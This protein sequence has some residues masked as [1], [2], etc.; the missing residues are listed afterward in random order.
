V[1]TRNREALFLLGDGGLHLNKPFKE[2]GYYLDN[3][4]MLSSTP[5][6]EAM[7]TDDP[8]MVEALFQ[9]GLD[10]DI[11]LEEPDWNRHPYRAVLRAS[12]EPAPEMI[13]ALL[14]VV[15]DEDV[16]DEVTMG[17][18]MAIVDR[19]LP[20]KGLLRHM[21]NGMSNERVRVH[22]ASN[23]LLKTASCAN[24]P[25]AQPWIRAMV[26]L[27]LDV[28]A[29]VDGAFNEVPGYALSM[30]V[31]GM[32]PS[33]QR[34]HLL[35]SLLAQEPKCD[36]HVELTLQSTYATEQ[37]TPFFFAV[38]NNDIMA[39]DAMVASGALEGQGLDRAKASLDRFDEPA[40]EVCQKGMRHARGLLVE[41]EGIALRASVE[42]AETAGAVDQPEAPRGRARL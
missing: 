1:R 16:R 27:L 19:E 5:L 37:G 20:Y 6:D 42:S 22:A 32:R 34:E 4:L 14:G 23:A 33:G 26:P 21:F 13:D 9:A 24:N 11:L 31:K 8:R 38:K 28:G 15:S 39:I 17:L 30:F 3:H 25:S 18:I 41:A 10:P 29:V 2:D 40:N 12:Y 36:V 35:K 7:R